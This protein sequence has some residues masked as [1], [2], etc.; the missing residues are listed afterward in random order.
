MNR[1]DFFRG[2]FAAGAIAVVPVSLLSLE[3]EQITEKIVK[4]PVDFNTGCILYKDGK[5]IAHS[6]DAKFETIRHVRSYR[7]KWEPDKEEYFPAPPEYTITMIIDPKAENASLLKH[8]YDGVLLEVV[9]INALTMV[10][11]K[12]HCQAYIEHIYIH[13]LWD[14]PNEIRLTV[15]GPIDLI[16][17][18]G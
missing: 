14:K 11:C 4:Q 12:V 7:S 17:E 18:R 10:Q 6:K 3:G 1:R 13:E 8:M 9:A 15:S 2:A 16:M 5:V